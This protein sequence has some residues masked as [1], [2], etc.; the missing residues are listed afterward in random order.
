MLN[1]CLS[2]QTEKALAKTRKCFFM[3]TSQGLNLEWQS[4]HKTH[5]LQKENARLTEENDALK[6]RI[7]S[8]D[9]NAITRL[10]DK[11][12]AEIKELQERVGKAESEAVRSGNKAY[13]EHQ[14][15]PKTWWRIYSLLLAAEAVS[16]QVGAVP[17]VNLPTGMEQRRIQAGEYNVEVCFHTTLRGGGILTL[18]L[19]NL[20]LLQSCMTAK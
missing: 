14:Q 5:Q 16:V 9:E 10:R 4:L 13:S 11:K 8:I 2:I 20:S 17:T 3:W 1:I 7:A 15:S 6:K 12:D 18:P 19:H